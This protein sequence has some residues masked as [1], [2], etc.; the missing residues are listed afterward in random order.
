MGA[1]YATALEQGLPHAYAEMPL[2]EPIPVLPFH[3]IPKAKKVVWRSL[4]GQGQYPDQPTQMI[5]AR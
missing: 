2:R 1:K 4:V 5:K 3:G